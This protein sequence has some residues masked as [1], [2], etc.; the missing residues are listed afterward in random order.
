M[1]CKKLSIFNTSVFYKLSLKS[2]N[3]NTMNY[4]LSNEIKKINLLDKLALY[5][6]IYLIKDKDK[7]IGYIW[8]SQ[9][10][11][12]K[13]NI[14][15]MYL[16][17]GDKNIF[18]HLFD[19]KII[20]YESNVDSNCNLLLDKCG[21]I[22][23][24]IFDLLYI[25]LFNKINRESFFL[26]E[27]ALKENI[28]FVKFTKDVNEQDRCDLQNN[29]F[30]DDDRIPIEVDDIY[31]DEDQDYYID[32]GLILMK[33]DNEFIGMGQLIDIDNNLTLVNFGI[34]ESYR[35]NGYAHI[36]L[37]KLINVAFEI[38]ENLNKSLL[39]LKVDKKND[40]AYKLYTNAG[41][42]FSKS[43]LEWNYNSLK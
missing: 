9:I 20:K 5:K 2:C 19:G 24:H 32:E 34:I 27:K 8:M 37:K 38:N 23:N 28:S 7:Y 43:I 11:N 1:K 17:Y 18:S 33:K 25:P 41:F 14:N 21:F 42:K 10:Y 15:D 35:H 16:E 4:D 40:Q 39:Y 30:N 26:D 36:L 31:F 13:Y 3:F 6:D 12:E 22:I 29:I